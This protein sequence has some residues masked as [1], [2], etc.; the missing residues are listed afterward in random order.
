MCISSLMPI[1]IFCY[2]PELCC[3]VTAETKPWLKAAQAFLFVKSCHPEH[4]NG[5]NLKTAC[6]KE[7][8]LQT[9]Q[10]Y[11]ELVRQ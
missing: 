1:V 9:L 6:F 10:H 3:T 2:D 8:E 5:I 4:K 7:P 11:Q